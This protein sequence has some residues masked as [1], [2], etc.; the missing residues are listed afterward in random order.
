MRPWFQAGGRLQRY[1]TSPSLPS[2]AAGLGWR[3]GMRGRGVSGGRLHGALLGLLQE[4]LG[5]HLIRKR[6]CCWYLLSSQAEV[7]KQKHRQWEQGRGVTQVRRWKASRR[8][9][10]VSTILPGLHS[11]LGKRAAAGVVPGSFLQPLRS[12]LTF[13]CLSWEGWRRLRS[14]QPGGQPAFT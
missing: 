7:R 6:L 4:L 3:E 10:G 5:C 9:P 2:E 8:A 11:Q 13:R 14:H 12:L 1:Q